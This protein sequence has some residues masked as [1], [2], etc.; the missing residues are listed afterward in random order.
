MVTDLSKQVSEI[1]RKVDLIL[2]WPEE[3]LTPQRQD[4]F[5]L[6]QFLTNLPVND[7]D[8]FCHLNEQVKNGKGDILLNIH[9]IMFHINSMYLLFTHEAQTYV[10]LKL[11][12]VVAQLTIDFVC[13]DLI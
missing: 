6:P 1:I 3:P 9:L 5:S 7:D 2:R 8:S 10:S 4:P 13:F 12:S 11:T